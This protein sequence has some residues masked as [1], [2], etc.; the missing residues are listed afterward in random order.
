MSSCD[1]P[2]LEAVHASRVRTRI[3]TVVLMAL[4][5]VA[6]K[7]EKPSRGHDEPEHGRQ[8]AEP[9]VAIVDSGIR[10]S[11]QTGVDAH[12]SRYTPGTPSDRT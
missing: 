10:L 8:N 3:V 1:S 7:H 12:W 9:I 5:V 4:A 2:Q 6:C 11:R